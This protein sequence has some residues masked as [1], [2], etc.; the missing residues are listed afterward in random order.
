[1]LQGAER[2][3]Q[4]P[5]R[6]VELFRGGTLGPASRG[7]GMKTGEEA[8][9]RGLPFESWGFLNRKGIGE[10][11]PRDILVGRKMN[12]L[13]VFLKEINSRRGPR[14]FVGRSGYFPRGDR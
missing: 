10:F 7:G 6:K 8:D 12:V 5:G 9:Q 3:G 2:V 13:P 14:R 1:M 11:P 4:P